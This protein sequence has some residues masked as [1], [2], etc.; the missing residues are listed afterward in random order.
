MSTIDLKL[1]RAKELIETA[2]LALTDAI[3]KKDSGEPFEAG[4]HAATA[5]RLAKEAVEVIESTVNDHR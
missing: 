2:L 3:E 4:Q 1:L 5:A